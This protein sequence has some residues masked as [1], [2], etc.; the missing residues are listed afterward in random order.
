[1]K[2]RTSHVHVHPLSGVPYGFELLTSTPLA[3]IAARAS[4]M[5]G[6]CIELH[7]ATAFV[8]ADAISDVVMPALENRADLRFLTGTFGCSTRQATFRELLKLVDDFGAEVRI[9]SCEAHQ[10][11]HWKLYLWRLEAATG[12]AWIG[13]ANLTNGGLQNDGEFVMEI[14]GNWDSELI[15]EARRGFDREWDRAD[16][17][18]PKF[19]SSY[20][21]APKRPPDA[22]ATGTRARK[23]GRIFVASVAHQYSETS[24]TFKRVQKL[25]GAADDWFRHRTKFLKDVRPGD[26]CILI[27]EVDNRVSLTEVTD[28]QLDGNHIVFSHVPVKRSRPHRRW[29]K[30]IAGR[31]RTA[32]LAFSGSTPRMRWIDPAIA[33]QVIGAIYER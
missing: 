12:V 16:L 1:M 18:T 8:S 2:T 13:S 29:T 28:V 25:L 19:V 22:A 27:D 5:S 14:T 10:N 23:K 31:L 20:K 6:R 4:G 30:R 26:R 21:E 7:I 32:G 17:I 15:L 9:W 11:F 24:P 33:D 3:P